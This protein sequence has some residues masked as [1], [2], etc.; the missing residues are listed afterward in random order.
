MTKERNAGAEQPQEEEPQGGTP[1]QPIAQDD[2]LLTE[3]Q[4]EVHEG[5]DPDPNP[6]QPN[7]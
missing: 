5:S 7:V 6:P 2:P 1:G 4:P 3:Q